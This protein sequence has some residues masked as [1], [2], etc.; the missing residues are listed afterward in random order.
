MK[1]PQFILKYYAFNVFNRDNWVKEQALSIPPGSNILDVGS[2]SAPYRNLFLHCNYKTHDFAK[3]KDIQLRDYKGYYKIDYL[4][5]ICN[6]PVKNQ[7]FEIV[8]CTEVLEHV[9]EPI[10]AIKEIYRI[11]KPGGTLLL[12]APL[13]SG[14]H[15]VPFHF[16]GGYTPFFYKKVLNDVGFNKIEVTPNGG[17]YSLFSQELI[18]LVRRSAP[19]K[20][21]INFLFF[22]FWIVFACLSILMPLISPILDNRYKNVD[23]TVGYHV[24]A[25]K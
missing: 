10:S 14:L 3:L 6:I 18:R 24:K 13:G 11:L 15:Q 19:W 7:S 5:D 20:S 23:F 17:F 2:G 22:P 9:P 12:T 1:L 21:L 16:Y 4:S 8:L 25:I